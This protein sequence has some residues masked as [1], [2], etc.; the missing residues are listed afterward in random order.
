MDQHVDAVRAIF[1]EYSRSD[2]KE[3]AALLSGRLREVTDEFLIRE[4]HDRPE[5]LEQITGPS[6]VPDQT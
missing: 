2:A 4:N 5:V 1:R 3:L 6:I